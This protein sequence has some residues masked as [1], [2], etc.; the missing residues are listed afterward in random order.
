M[1]TKLVV[2]FLL[3]SACV[4]AELIDRIVAIVNSEIVT[5]S[6]LRTFSK[7]L[8]QNGMIDD[9]L[10][11]GESSASLQANPK[12]QLNYLINERLLESE[13]K[14]LNLSVTVE[15]VE[16]EI[17]DI[18]KRNHVG[19]TELLE[20][21]K[22]QG[23]TV[24]EYQD[25]IKTRVERQSLIETEVSSKIRVADEDVLAQYARTHPESN[26]GSFEYTLAH[27]LL[28]PKKGGPERAQERAEMAAKKISAGESFETVAEQFSEDP[29][30][31]SGGLLGTFRA[32]E[33]SKDLEVAVQG[34]GIGEVTGIV[35]S[36]AG[37][38]IVKVLSKKVILDPA[39]EK[40][41][42]KIRSEIFDRAFQKNFQIWLE[43]KREE[44]FVRINAP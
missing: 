27:I 16:Q 42:E 22:A 26:T 2:F 4:R 15:R 17:R 20:A 39:F 40:V 41:R 24:S 34:L 5:Q 29:N 36:R 37:L 3:F 11:L 13:I 8:S 19:R 38:H 23:I 33:F 6:D 21:I 28:N 7:K 43:N 12:G 9:L 32:G 25:F 18:A 10:L 1:R 14:R 31:T 30:F 35:R 44:S